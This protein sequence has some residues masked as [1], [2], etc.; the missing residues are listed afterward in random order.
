MVD[1]AP[2]EAPRGPVSHGHYVADPRTLPGRATRAA[3]TKEFVRRARKLGFPALR[4]HDLRG[5]NE[6]ALLLDAGIVV[7]VVAARCG[8]DP[9]ILFR[10]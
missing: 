4:F 7:H 5:T 9:A 3:L 1:H 8:D 2:K 6:N 10:T